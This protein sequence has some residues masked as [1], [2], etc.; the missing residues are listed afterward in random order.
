[1]C[2][3]QQGSHSRNDVADKATLHGIG[4]D[5][6]EG[7]LTLLHV[8]RCEAAARRTEGRHTAASHA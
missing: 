2:R 7:A 4:L 8:E 6:D 3:D 5:H 1:M